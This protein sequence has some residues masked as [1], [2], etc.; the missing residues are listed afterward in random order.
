MVA[1][2]IQGWGCRFRLS[3][4]YCLTTHCSSRAAVGCDLVRGSAKPS[5]SALSLSPPKNDGKVQARTP[6]SSKTTDLAATARKALAP[7]VF[8][9]TIKAEAKTIRHLRCP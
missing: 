4:L 9:T 1:G 6:T 5:A 8:Q 7:T 3:F 2:G